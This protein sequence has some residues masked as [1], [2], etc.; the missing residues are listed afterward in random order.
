MFNPDHFRYYKIDEN[1]DI[2]H[3]GGERVRAHSLR[4]YQTIDTAGTENVDS[5]YFV[6]LTYSIDEQNRVYIRD[7]FREKR[8][9]TKHERELA[10]AE[11]KWNPIYQAVE[12]K[13]FGLNLIQSARKRGRPI[14]QL[15]ADAS[16]VIRAEPASVH[17]ENGMVFHPRAPDAHW[18]TTYESELVEFPRGKHDDQVDCIAYAV[19]LA[20]AGDFELELNADRYDDLD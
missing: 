15:I 10:R 19:Q 20:R 11:S 17:Y 14:R 1:G 5:D 6:I 4:T 12:K 8:D 2:I 7:V 18:L 9:T 3:D 16:K 13:V